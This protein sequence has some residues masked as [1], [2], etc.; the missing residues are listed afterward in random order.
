MCLCAMLWIWFLLTAHWKK[1]PYTCQLDKHPNWKSYG[2]RTYTYSVYA[3]YK[4][5]SHYTTELVHYVCGVCNMFMYIICIYCSKS[6]D[7]HQ[8]DSHFYIYTHMMYT[9]YSLIVCRLSRFLNRQKI[10]SSI[11]PI[12]VARHKIAERSHHNVVA[13]F[14]PQLRFLSGFVLNCG[15]F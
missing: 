15:H 10:K 8:I 2:Q 4:L 7:A 6:R 9:F 11:R 5:S 12:V 13:K 1:T 14:H 3:K